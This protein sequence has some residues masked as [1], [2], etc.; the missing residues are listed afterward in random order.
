M[1]EF[2]L[3]KE[4]NIENYS[5][6]DRELIIIEVEQRIGE[7]VFADLPEE[8]ER[9]F[10]EIIYDNIEHI[11]WWL[12]ENDPEYKESETFK[13]TVEIASEDGNPDNIRPEKVYATI[14]WI[15]MNVPNYGEI[16]QQ[17]AAGYRDYDWT[18]YLKERE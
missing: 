1:N 14:R 10:R 6:H 8:K 15:E 16:A 13:D 18:E 5:E 9:E 11:D 17:V 12:G 3:E 4:L 2:D 7:K